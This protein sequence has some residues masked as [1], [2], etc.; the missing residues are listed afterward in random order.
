VP[1]VVSLRDNLRT[2]GVQNT[3][4]G[5]RLVVDTLEPAVGTW[6]QARGT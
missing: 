6:I 2:S 5:Q 3:H 1:T 4:E